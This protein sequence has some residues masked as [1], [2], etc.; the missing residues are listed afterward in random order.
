MVLWCFGALNPSD[1]IVSVCAQGFCC[2]LHV[3]VE[4]N[5][6]ADVVKEN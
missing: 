4:L 5:V 1:P 6:F 2:V 3:P